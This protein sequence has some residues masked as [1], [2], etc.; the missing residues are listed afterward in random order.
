[1]PEGQVTQT[2]DQVS[3]T[4]S[5]T[6]SL[7]WRAALPDEFKDHEFVKTFQKPGDFVKSA[8]EIKTEAD[9]L[10]ARLANAVIKPGENASPAEITAY[11]LALGVPEKSTDYE[12]PKGEGLRDELVQ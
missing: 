8:L 4:Q 1:M 12:F 10:K 5:D 3:Q 7:G 9:G 2:G 11:R 6:Q